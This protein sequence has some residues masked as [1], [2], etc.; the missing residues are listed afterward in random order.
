VLY[1]VGV[2]E[3]TD[4]LSDVE[5][6]AA[7][8]RDFRA[9]EPSDPKKFS[10]QVVADVG[11]LAGAVAE[12]IKRAGK[13]ASALPMPRHVCALADVAGPEPARP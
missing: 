7:R 3:L 13:S 10:K 2:R 11:V 9:D 6:I 12:L 5:D 8:A 4:Y 1:R